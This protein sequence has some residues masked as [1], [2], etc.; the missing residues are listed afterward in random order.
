MNVYQD[1]NVMN[2][3]L[4]YTLL[5]IG[6]LSFTAK[7]F[8]GSPTTY[9]DMR[10]SLSS[11]VWHN[12]RASYQSM[13]PNNLGISNVGFHRGPELGWYFYHLPYIYKETNFE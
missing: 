3:S 11:E 12:S 9:Q 8:L 5:T 6:Q 1:K 4:M 7:G 2:S 10:I 13:N